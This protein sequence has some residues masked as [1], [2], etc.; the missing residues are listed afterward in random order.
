MVEDVA[1]ISTS[2]SAALDK[3]GHRVVHASDAEQ[4]IQ[5]AEV[6]RPALILTD[7]ELPTF[8]K[9][10]NLL[11]GHA[12]LNDTVVAIIDLNHPR[13]DGHI[14]VLPDFQALDDLLYASGNSDPL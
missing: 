3:R 7:L 2:M 13:V 5:L 9:L 10:L 8:D 1:E 14:R 12:D 11:R 6:N 4:A